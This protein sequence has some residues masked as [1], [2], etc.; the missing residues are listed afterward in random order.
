MKTGI[1]LGFSK[2]AHLPELSLTLTSHLK[3]NDGLGEGKV[4]FSR[5][6]KLIRKM[7]LRKKWSNVHAMCNDE[8]KGDLTN[9]D[10]FKFP[11]KKAQEF[12]AIGCVAS[13]QHV[14]V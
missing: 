3:Q 5:K 4:A 2:T 10:I 9:K 13:Y 14:T 6:P 7:C 11:A 1:N 12:H 8:K